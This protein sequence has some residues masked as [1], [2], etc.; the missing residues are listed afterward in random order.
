[1]SDRQL[2]TNER[3]MQTICQK[4]I[5]D[6]TTMIDYVAARR[7]T[8]DEERFDRLSIIP[9]DHGLM[10]L[11]AREAFYALP[12]A[13]HCP[14]TLTE[15]QRTMAVQCMANYMMWRWLTLVSPD[16]AP[17]FREQS[18]SIVAR[19]TEQMRHADSGKRTRR[20]M[21]PF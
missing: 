16:E 1:M 9:P 15:Q 8:D 18:D 13:C 5:H 6:M 14:A 4:A 11:L 12:T 17:P 3:V 7:R 10:L 21:F 2:K 19:L 20:P